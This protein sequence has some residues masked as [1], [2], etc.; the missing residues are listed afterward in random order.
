MKWMTNW[1]WI[2]VMML[3]YTLSLASYCGGGGGGGPVVTLVSIS[4]TPANP[5]ISA[6]LTKQFAATGTYSDGTS[7]D[8][9][10]QVI[11]SSSNTSVATINGSGL[12]TGVAA[13]NSTIT[14]T[15]ASIS[16]NTT[17]RVTRATFGAEEL[18]ISRAQLEAVGLKWWPDGVMGVLP[19]TI[20]GQYEFFAANSSNIG[21]ATG[22]LDHPI[23]GSVT[24][25][26]VIGGMKHA[27]QYAAG[28][29][30]YIDQA[31]Q[32]RLLFYHAEIWPGGDYH[33]YY[34]VIGMAR[35]TDAGRS[36][37]DLGEIIRPNMPIGV[38]TR[39]VEIFSGSYTVN[40]DYF[41]VYFE[42]FLASGQVNCLAVA[43]A[44][45][46]DVLAAAINS[47]DVVGWNKFYNG[48]WGEPALG[49][50][51]SSLELGNP[52]CYWGD[53]SYNDYI[54]RYLL[55]CAS[56][57][58]P[59]IY[60]LQLSESQDGLNWSPRQVVA[61]TTT[62]DEL[63]DPTLV[64]LGADSRKSSNQLYVYYTRSVAGGW[65]RWSDA[66]LMR[67]LISFAP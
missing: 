50:K 58:D 21:Q 63:C 41:Y 26:I 1:R 13:G 54:Q 27:Y 60:T 66:N 9:T 3:F 29:P 64:G 5:S 45:V 16:A 57:A 40:G 35:S 17:L 18:I 15:S 43:R 19:T 56:Y 20:S 25:A 49:G 36:W 52:S 42:D 31:T 61:E 11:W 62:T 8:I 48:S 7:D 24:P 39:G 46:S 23:I 47:A 2:K 30:V 67:R 38:A 32:T 59:G 55:V 51:S 6:G 44:R 4:V 10:T 53:V 22:T 12:A 34:A 65:N 14:A 33:N 37:T 28:G